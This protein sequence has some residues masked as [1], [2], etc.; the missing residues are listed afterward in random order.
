MRRSHQRQQGVVLLLVALIVLVGSSAL[1]LSTLSNDGSLASLARGNKQSLSEARDALLGY[2]ISYP[3]NHSGAQNAPPGFL[4]CPDVDGD[5]LEDVDQCNDPDESS[6][7][8]LPWRTLGLAKPGDSGDQVHCLWYAVSGGFKSPADTAGPPILNSSSV[9]KFQIENV[10]GDVIVGTSAA[11]RAIAV[12]F[13]PGPVLTIDGP[14]PASA[15]YLQD[16]LAASTKTVCG[17]VNTSNKIN[18]AINYL[19]RLNGISN[20]DGTKQGAGGS[21][22]GASALPTDGVSVFVTAS[23]QQVDNGPSYNDQLI[24]IDRQKFDAVFERM[25]E[26]TV[27]KV[28]S[29][30]ARY[31]DLNVVGTRRYPWAAN[32]DS[33]ADPE[34]DEQSGQ[35]F[36]RIPSSLS[37]PGGTSWPPDPDTSTGTNCFNWSWWPAWQEEIFYAVHDQH[38]DPVGAGSTVLELDGSASEF[39]VLLANEELSG[40]SRAGYTN[41]GRVQNYLE[42]QNQ[43][44]TGSATIPS[45]D[46]TFVNGNGSS[47][48]DLACNNAG[49]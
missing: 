5:G 28:Q 24:W 11:D 40:Q 8:F 33:T 42:G 30:V 6:I 27:N 9:G 4:P 31:G 25:N 49:C 20:A 45:G 14:T 48:N 35:R 29:C 7:G 3:E 39:V 22:P 43:P 41:K 13:D 46:E 21:Y 32:L 15:D 17:A 37:S 36:G 44:A 16:R 23:K 10:R 34:Y 26:W 12:V 19:D 1:I 18:L 38:T 2:A 47:V